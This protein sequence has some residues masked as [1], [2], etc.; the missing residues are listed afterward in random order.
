MTSPKITPPQPDHPPVA[1]DER[2]RTAIDLLESI[3]ADRALLARVPQDD[4][5]RLLQAAGRVSRPDARLRR[6]VAKAARRQR[7]KDKVE[8]EESVLAETGIRKLRREV[9]FT[10][11]NVF[12]PPGF[13]PQDVTAEPEFREMIESKHCY[14]CKQH[15]TSSA[16]PAPR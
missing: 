4:R 6:Q 1:L 11:P 12:P 2:L 15:Y 7:Q 14:V 9:V 3:A 16:R 8:R 13:A 10:T 5:L